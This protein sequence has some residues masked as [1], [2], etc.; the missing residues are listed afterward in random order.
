MTFREKKEACRNYMLMLANKYQDTHV[1]V[2]SPY[3]K[4]TLMLVPK[5]TEDQV[6][7]YGKPK[8][9]YRYATCWNWYANEKK[10]KDP[11]YIQCFNH[12]LPRAK[13]RNAPGSGSDPVFGICVAYTNNGKQYHHI[14]G[15]KYDRKKHEWYFGFCDE[16]D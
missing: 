16:E 15:E 13:K 2:T 9:S 11:N 1:L 14:F 7:W 12:D 3:N 5:G 6:T 4:D 8:D 10:C